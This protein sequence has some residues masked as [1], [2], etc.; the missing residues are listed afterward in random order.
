MT[1]FGGVGGPGWDVRD[2]YLLMRDE[3][4]E[5]PDQ[6]EARD[7][8]DLAV[9][10]EAAGPTKPTLFERFTRWFSAKF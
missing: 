2:A 1:G 4:A 10:K 8:Y 5:L 3:E 6:D 9:E 7:R